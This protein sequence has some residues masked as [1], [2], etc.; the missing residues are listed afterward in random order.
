MKAALRLFGLVIA[1]VS[2]TAQAAPLIDADTL[3]K[4]LGEPDLVIVDIRNKIDGGSK[5]IFEAAHIP[6]A[7]YSNYLTSGW[8]TKVDGVV[9]MA[10]TVATLEA[11]IGNLGISNDDH[12]VIVHGGVNTTDFGSAARVYWTLKYLGHD[13]VSILDGGFKSW[14]EKSDRPLETGPVVIDEPALF[15]SNLRPELLI[16]TEEVAATLNDP[17]VVRIDARPEKQYRGKAKHKMALA[18]GRIPGS[19]GI[20][21]AIFFDEKARLLPTEQLL[22]IVPEDVKSGHADMV[23]SYCNTGHWAATNWFILSEVLG[24]TQ[25]RLYDGSMTGWTAKTDNPLALGDDL[26]DTISHWV[27]EKKS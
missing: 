2:L 9:G 13:R 8:R 15:S 3:H 19:V 18:P 10:P 22:E 17:K 25:A 24:F 5:K 16:S 26:F 12:V 20:E 7:V 11:I 14:T 21:Q 6:G 4:R 27:P 23:V 1:L